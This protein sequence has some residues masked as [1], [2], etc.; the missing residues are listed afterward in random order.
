MGERPVVLMAGREVTYDATAK[1]AVARRAEGLC[2]YCGHAHNRMIGCEVCGPE[3]CP[4]I[5][6]TDDPVAI[7]TLRAAFVKPEQ[8]KPSA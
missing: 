4:V 5:F 3:Q 1:R 6:E 2:G 8:A 7:E